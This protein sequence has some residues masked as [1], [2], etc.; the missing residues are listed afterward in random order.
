MLLTPRLRSS[1]TTNIFEYVNSVLKGER[2]LPVCLLVKSTY[3]RLIELF[4]HKR[5]EAKAK[6][7]TGQ[8]YSQHLMKAIEANLKASR[9][10]T[11]ILYNKDNSELTVAE[12]TPTGSFSLGS[13]RTS[14]SY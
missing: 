12:T 8:Q 7:R 3:G 4:V 10:F 2:N 14:P 6:L 1:L 5:R 13:Y 11:V 9:C